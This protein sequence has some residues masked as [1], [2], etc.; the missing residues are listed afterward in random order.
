M[1]R[2]QYYVAVL[3]TSTFAMWWNRIFLKNRMK[4][5]LQRYSWGALQ[6]QLQYCCCHDNSQRAM[7]VWRCGCV[8]MMMT[9]TSCPRSGPSVSPWVISW[10]TLCLWPYRDLVTG[11]PGPAAAKKPFITTDTVFCSYKRFLPQNR[12]LRRCSDSMAKL[13]AATA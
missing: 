11:K 2:V 7:T 1:P 8:T 5:T 10:M 6:P 9:M 12:D 13:A 4:K 3:V